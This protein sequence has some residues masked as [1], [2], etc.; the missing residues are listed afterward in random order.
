MPAAKALCG[1]VS[2][3][4]DVGWVFSFAIQKAVWRLTQSLTQ[5]P[6]LFIQVQFFENVIQSDF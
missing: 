2:G 6:A 4:C 1:S 5:I 3:F